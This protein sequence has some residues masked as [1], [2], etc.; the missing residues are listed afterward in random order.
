MC[1]QINLCCSHPDQMADSI[2]GMCMQ[3]DICRSHP[4]QVAD[5]R[6]GMC[7]LRF[8]TVTQH[9]LSIT[10]RMGS[11]FC[12]RVIRVFLGGAGGS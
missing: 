4:D 12:S 3:V 9:W 10:A 1:T 2:D 6:D 11:N 7:S 5:R 8:L